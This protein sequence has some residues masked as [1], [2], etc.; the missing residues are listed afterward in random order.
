MG[1]GGGRSEGWFCQFD[2]GGSCGRYPDTSDELGGRVL[3][4]VGRSCQ[5]CC[6][7][8]GGPVMDVEL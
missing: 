1:G 3:A 6:C 5:C 4:V 8:C 2:V 7:C